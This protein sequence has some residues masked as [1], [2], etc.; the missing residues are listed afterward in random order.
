MTERTGPLRDVRVVE[1]ASLAPAPFA[2]CLLADMGADVIRVD[3]IGPRPMFA[4]PLLDRGKRSIA[5]DLKQ[6]AGVGLVLDLVEQADILIEG[7]R[8]GV[9]ERLGVGPAE[10]LARRPSLVYGRMTGFGQDGPLA[11]SA[12]HDIDYIALSGV[13]GRLGRAGQPPTPPLNLVGDFGGGSMF[14]V[15]GVLCALHEA[16]RTGV[17]QVVDAAMVEGSGYLMLPFFGGGATT[18]PASPRGTGVLDSGAPFYDAYETSDGKWVAVGAMEPQFYAALLAGLGLDPAELPD[19]FDSASW[20]D[21][22][23]RFAAA[24][25]GR[26]RAEWEKV[27][28]GTDAC[29]APVLDFDELADHPHLQARGFL[30]T[31]EGVAQ[32]GPAPKLSST[33]GRVAGP[34]PDTGQHTAEILAEWLGLDEPAVGAMHRDGTVA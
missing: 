27:F 23:R 8:P 28:A 19:Q 32:P 3:R 21:M 34:P 22:K 30:E 18:R 11:H 2:A 9:T 7:Y 1:L 31:H 12:G 5:V 10:C 33:P 20:P 13:L 17:G 16:R 24:F 29:V 15:F 4:S 26:T 14:L 25:A 6:P